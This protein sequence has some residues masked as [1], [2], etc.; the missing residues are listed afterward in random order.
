MPKVRQFLANAFAMPMD[1]RLSCDMFDDPITEMVKSWAFKG[2]SSNTTPASATIRVTPRYMSKTQVISKDATQSSIPARLSQHKM[3]TTP[4]KIPIRAHLY[5]RSSSE[6]STSLGRPT[7]RF[8]TSSKCRRAIQSPHRTKKKNP[9]KC[10]AA[11]RLD[12]P[13]LGLLRLYPNWASVPSWNMASNQK[14]QM[15]KSTSRF[16]KK[17]NPK[18]SQF[19]RNNNGGNPSYT[20]MERAYDIPS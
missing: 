19:R 7:A 4:V 16:A 18:T 1:V 12:M 14:T 20:D 5:D 9:P 3:Y 15:L 8:I 6:S 11:V 10:C 17:A 2:K 13:V